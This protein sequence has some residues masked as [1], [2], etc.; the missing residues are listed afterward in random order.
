MYSEKCIESANDQVEQIE[1]QYQEGLTADG[2]RHNKVI[3]IWASAPP[4]GTCHNVDTRSLGQ[5][6]A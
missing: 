2:E 5:N 3:D 4:A 1:E 6:A